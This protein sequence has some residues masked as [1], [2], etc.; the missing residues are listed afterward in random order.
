[1]TSHATAA[2]ATSSVATA[3]KPAQRAASAASTALLAFVACLAFLIFHVTESDS[4]RPFIVLLC[5]LGLGTSGVLHLIF[6]R[7]LALRLGLQPARYVLAAL[8]TLPVG[9]AVA[10]VLYDWHSKVDTAP[11]PDHAA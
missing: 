4:V 3:N 8:F 5:C 1:M 11:A 2:A 9:S 7:L 10:L 6:V